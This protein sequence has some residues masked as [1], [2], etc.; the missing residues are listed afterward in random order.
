MVIAAASVSASVYKYIIHR[1]TI[2]YGAGHAIFAQIGEKRHHLLCRS[3]LYLYLYCI[4]IVLSY[5]WSTCM[6]KMPVR[7]TISFHLKTLTA[8]TFNTFQVY[9]CLLGWPP[10]FGR[11]IQAPNFKSFSIQP[12]ICVHPV[13]MLRL[14][15]NSCLDDTAHELSLSK[16]SD[17]IVKTFLKN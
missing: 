1:I 17:F 3:T 8:T 6:N 13:C 2:S 12:E 9:E 15:I 11:N 16:L 4:Y 14:S 5:L 7:F 10:F